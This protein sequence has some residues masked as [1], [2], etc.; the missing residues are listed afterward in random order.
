VSAP[1]IAGVTREQA[2]FR[3]IADVA[4]QL[5]R[6]VAEGEA[7]WAKYAA[8]QEACR[9]EHVAVDVELPPGPAAWHAEWKQRRATA[10]ARELAREDERCSR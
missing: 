5:R 4:D 8:A 1:E 7:L 3:T 10:E 9:G 2:A 6:F